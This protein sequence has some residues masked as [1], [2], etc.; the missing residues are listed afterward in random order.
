[1]NKTEI[2]NMGKHIGLD[3]GSVSVKLAVLDSKG[4]ILK[5]QYVRH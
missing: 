5:T 3:A 2:L 4:N 1:M